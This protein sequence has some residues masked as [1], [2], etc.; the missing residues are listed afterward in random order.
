MRRGRWTRGCA[1]CACSPPC[2]A[3]RSTTTRSRRSSSLP[4]RAESDGAAVFVHCG[5]LSVGVRKKLGLPSAFDIAFGN[6]T[7]L[8][9]LALKFPTVP[10][11][12]PHFGA[13]LLREALMLADLCPNVYLDTSS[14][15]SWIVHAGANAR[16]GFPGRAERGGSRSAVVRQRFVL[17]PARME[18]KCV[19]GSESLAGQ[20]WRGKRRAGKDLRRQLRAALWG[21]GPSTFALTRFGGQVAPRRAHRFRGTGITQV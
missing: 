16:A 3:T 9:A 14:S 5:V 15:N 7:H 10:L 11:I 19:R 18:S 21:L 2:T 13:G 1:R 8:H 6:P 20:S 17:L 4:N 12:V